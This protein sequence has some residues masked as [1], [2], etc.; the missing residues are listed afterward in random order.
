MRIFEAKLFPN[1]KAYFKF[2]VNRDV[3]IRFKN[4]INSEI[5]RYTVQYIYIYKTFC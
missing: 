1:Y 3:I 4:N 5:R 2:F